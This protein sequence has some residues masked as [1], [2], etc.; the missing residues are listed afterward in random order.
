MIEHVS[1]ILADA[2]THLIYGTLGC[3]TLLIFAAIILTPLYLL[4]KRESKK[5][6]EN[7]K[8]KV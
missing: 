2:I 5:E 1:F 3:I 7:A 4:G 8:H 6:L